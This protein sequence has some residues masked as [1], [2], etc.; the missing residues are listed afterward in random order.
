[1]AEETKLTR[2]TALKFVGA[3]G[4]FGATAALARNVG[5]A[6]GDSPCLGSH[7][8]ILPHTETTAV[9]KVVAMSQ[10][11]LTN[12]LNTIM[13]QYSRW[14]SNEVFLWANPDGTLTIITTTDLAEIEQRWV[15]YLSSTHYPGGEHRNSDKTGR[16]Y[17]LLDGDYYQIDTT[18][19]VKSSYRAAF[20]F[21]TWPDGVIGQMYWR[22][23]SWTP[24]FEVTMPQTLLNML[25]AYENAWQ[26]GDVEARLALV[27][28]KTICSAVRIAGLDGRRSRFLATTKDELRAGWTSE[29]YGKVIELE[30]LYQVISTYYISAAYRLVLDVEG[31]RVVRETAALFPLGPKRKFMGELS[32]SFES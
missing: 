13:S 17:D 28:D 25:V 20:L 24:A 16:W 7:G 10:A 9:D 2:R 29:S 6:G 14:D 21:V 5:Y 22:E 30:R 15:T 8:L 18:T 32:Y 31:R 4:A 3:L 23:P 27:E 19:G 11:T 1:M 12:D 26:S